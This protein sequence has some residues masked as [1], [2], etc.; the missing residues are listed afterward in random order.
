MRRAASSARF[1]PAFLA[2]AILAAVSLATAAPAVAETVYE[3]DLSHSDVS[4]Q[5]RH[6]MSKVR[7]AFTEFSGTIVRNDEDLSKASVEFKIATASIDT[8][9]ESR[10][11]HLRSADFFDVEKHPE[12]VFKSTAVEKV[13]DN[14]Y[15]VTGQFSLHGVTKEIVLPVA[16]EGEVKDPRGTVRAGFSVATRIDR[17]EY[18]ME[19]NRALDSGGYLLSDDV[20]VEIQIEAKQKAPEPAPAKQ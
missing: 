19:W 10:D 17:K 7:G 15:R 9:H 2:T 12:I 13:S 11:E 20:V 3:I 8:R 4:F 1:A 14:Q 5:I 6:F 18:G 16:Y